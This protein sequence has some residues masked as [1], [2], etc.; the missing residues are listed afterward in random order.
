MNFDQAKALRLQQ[1]RSTLDDHDFRMQNPEA[2]RQT[3]HAMSATL[4]DVGAGQA[5]SGGREAFLDPQQVD[6][7]AS[8]RGT[9]G[10]A[11][12][13]A[14]EGMVLQVEKSGGALDV[15]GDFG[16]GHLLTCAKLARSSAKV[17]ASSH[18]AT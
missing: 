13:L 15:G 16:A 17:I 11:G 10:L 2:H 5:L 14:G 12:D 7:R 18:E 6:D 9:E 4:F 8:G 1:W 3:L